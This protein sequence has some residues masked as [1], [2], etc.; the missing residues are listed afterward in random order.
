MTESGVVVPHVMALFS[1]ER[2]YQLQATSCF[3]ATLLSFV[4]TKDWL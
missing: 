1:M 3:Y 2:V 4:C